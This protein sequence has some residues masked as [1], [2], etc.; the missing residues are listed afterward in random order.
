MDFN[1][2]PLQLLESDHQNNLFQWNM[3]QANLAVNWL[4]KY[5][6]SLIISSQNIPDAIVDACTRAK[7]SI[8]TH[9]SSLEIEWLA[10]SLNIEPVSSILSASHRS[11]GHVNHCQIISINGHQCVHLDG[12]INELYLPAPCFMLICGLLDSV[13]VQYR[14]SLKATLQ[15]LASWCKCQ[16]IRILCPKCSTQCTDNISNSESLHERE[17]D[18]EYSLNNCHL[19]AVKGGGELEMFWAEELFNY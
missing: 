11:V 12:F 7:I 2:A 8:V 13:A 19:L 14:D 5:Q 3:R 17:L 15:H 10:T 1:S 18:D 16:D 6:I 9:V 4:Q